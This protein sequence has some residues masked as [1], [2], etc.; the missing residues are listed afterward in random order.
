MTTLIND[1]RA[2]RDD[3]LGR[4]SRDAADL[5]ERYGAIRAAKAVHCLVSA[6]PT[7]A[8]ICGG[9]DELRRRGRDGLASQLSAVR[10]VEPVVTSGVEV[11]S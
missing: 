6:L 1:L 9:I 2:Q 11:R 8:V 10:F 7:D 5:T 4:L 3:L